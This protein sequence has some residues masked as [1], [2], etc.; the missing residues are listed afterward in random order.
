MTTHDCPLSCD[1]PELQSHGI[2]TTASIH[3]AVD[4]AAGETWILC[5]GAV[6]STNK[7]SPFLYSVLLRDI[8][9]LTRCGYIRVY[10]LM[11]YFLKIF[12]CLPFCWCTCMTI[13][14]SVQCR[15]TPVAQSAPRNLLTRWDVSSIPANG[16]FLTKN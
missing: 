11:M 9:M 13:N 4:L 2:H 5:T 1:A 15:S 7:V 8:I 12:F 6:Q 10:C 16:I 14:G 3:F